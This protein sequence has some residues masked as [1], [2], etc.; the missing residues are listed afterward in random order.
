MQRTE[1][2]SERVLL[3]YGVKNGYNNAFFEFCAHG[4]IK[5]N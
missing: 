4:E 2:E 3:H 5:G 1:K